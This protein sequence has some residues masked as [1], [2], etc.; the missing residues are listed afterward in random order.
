MAWYVKNHCPDWPFCMEYHLLSGVQGPFAQRVY[1]LIIQI[2][3]KYMLHLYE[4][5]Q[6]SWAVVTCANVWADGAIRIKPVS[7]DFDD[8][9][10][11]P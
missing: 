6:A 10:M 7:Q 11:N 2:L 3:Q 1:R 5:W 8:E 4:K 9:P